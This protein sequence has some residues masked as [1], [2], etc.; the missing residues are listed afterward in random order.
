MN[1]DAVS[2]YVKDVQKE[3]NTGIA[4]EHAYRPALER[5][6][7]SVDSR[8]N[9]VNDPKH[10]KAGA[11]DFIILRERIPVAFV[12]AKDIGKDLSR[13][14]NDEQMGRYRK[15]L[16][17]LLLTDYL[18]FRWYV[19]GQHR[20]TVTLGE[21]QKGKIRPNEAG[22]TAVGE[23]LNDFIRQATPVVKSARELAGY[24]ASMTR[25]ICDLV[26]A[27]LPDSPTLQNQ[28]AAFEQTLI[29]NLSDRDFADMY[30]Q[31]LAYGLFAARVNY[32][33]AKAT[34]TRRGVAEDIPKTNPF[35]R[36]MF[37]AILDDMDERVTWMVDALI[38]LLAH[39]DTDEILTG[40]GRKTKQEDPILHFYETFLAE[41]DPKMRE[42][43]GVYYT[44]EPVV[45]YI[46]RSVDHLLRERFGRAEGLADE[47]TLILDPAT[48][49]GT[50]L[51]SVI[52]QI[53]EGF[54]GQEGMWDGYVSRSLLPRIFGFELLVASYA[55]AHMKMGVMLRDTGYKFS[56]GQRLNIFLT[57][58]LEEGIKQP[59]LPLAGFISDEANAAV[60]IKREK[61]IMVVLGNPPYSYESANRGKWISDLVRDYYQ[62]DGKPL[63]ERNSKGLQD[64]YVKFIRF[65]QWRI[66]QTGS[67]IL[68]FVTNH[69]YLDGPTF[70]G[71]RQQL[72]NEFTDIYILNLHGNSNK[73]EKTPEGD[74]D[75]NVFD[76]QQGVAIGIF[77]KSLGAVSS[78]AR[79]HYADLWGKRNDK[80][81]ALSTNNLN[82]TIWATLE[83]QAPF[84]FFIPQN[85]DLKGEYDEGWKITDVMAVNSVGI[86]TSRD[87]LSIK[88]S[89]EEVLQVVK[90]FTALPIETA[91]NK[92]ELGED[93]R[94]WKVELAQKDIHK[95]G[96][97]Q[98]QIRPVYYRPF[99]SRY[100]YYTGHSRGFHSMPRFEVMR[101]MLNGENMALITSRLTKGEDFRHIQVTQH[102]VE[103]ICMSSKTS[104]NGFVFPL[105]LY[106]N[107]EQQ[108]LGGF[109]SEWEAGVGGR[110]PNLSVKFVREMEAKLGLKFTT[111]PPLMSITLPLKMCSIMPTPFS[112]ARPTANVTPN[113]S[114]LIS[115]AFRSRPMSSCSVRCA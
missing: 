45:S 27:S 93:S 60:A 109:D 75:D 21:V 112:T 98:T 48:G 10:I 39:A 108:K 61:N 3:F 57:N 56:S 68:A 41:Y 38:N 16:P 49:T 84:Y 64:D 89:S 76:I 29:P 53:Y 36:K 97:N 2:A 115:H 24:M 15:A 94:D 81:K 30:A 26:V 13:V 90:D 51:Y 104:N 78:S 11:P 59:P 42:S 88:W 72:M 6:L 19:D 47:Q 35:L 85:L 67:G 4:A 91:R 8:L 95:H 20:R 103:K 55:V 69:G 82:S 65:G 70:R 113:S 34:F 83:P 54:K 73:K 102:I 46:V 5:L 99:D 74:K 107:P 31:T 44:P 114:K 62:V 66:G 77:V 28:K 23:L 92:Y 22:F 110:V 7:E 87:D 63:G 33:G 52:Q 105:Y 50:F 106:P 9:A 25:E 86:V 17:N 96:I 100:T 37:S 40:F 80:Y 32:V 12:E 79:V 1:I 101:H 43:R 14:E 111:T 71:M 18:E 58:T